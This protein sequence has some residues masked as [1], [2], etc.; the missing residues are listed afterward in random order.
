MSVFE[1]EAPVLLVVVAVNGIEDDELAE[2]AF[3]D[4]DGDYD[5]WVVCVEAESHSAVVVGSSVENVLT[6]LV[7]VVVDVCF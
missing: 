1:F 2:A 6:G 4:A 3:D 5:A 7:G